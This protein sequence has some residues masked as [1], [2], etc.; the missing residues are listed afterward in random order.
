MAA[1]AN[2]LGPATSVFRWRGEPR[3]A[4]EVVLLMKTVER[5]RRALIARVAE[6][7][8]YAC[9]SIIVMPITD[10]HPGYLAWL[11][12]AVAPL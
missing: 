11:D 5:Q 10:G 8:A 2:I 1:A 4:T 12:E 7:H 6:L 9:P 3:T